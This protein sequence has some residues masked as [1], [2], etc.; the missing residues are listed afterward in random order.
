[1]FFPT[2]AGDRAGAPVFIAATAYIPPVTM[3]TTQVLVCGQST[4]GLT[5]GVGY[6]F[7][8]P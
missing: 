6:D 8:T 7:G 4:D 5:T 1:M 2:L 3:V